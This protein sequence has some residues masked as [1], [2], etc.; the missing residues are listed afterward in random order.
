MCSTSRKYLQRSTQYTHRWKNV[1]IA[2]GSRGQK[3]KE[4]KGETSSRIQAAHTANMKL[5][6]ERN[7]KEQ[8]AHI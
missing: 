5:E 7:V 6:N 3:I 8:A 1:T 2:I 4:E